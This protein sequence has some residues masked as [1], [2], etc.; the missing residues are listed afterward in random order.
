MN[1]ENT[2]L[3]YWENIL[4]ELEKGGFGWV[5]SCEGVKVTEVE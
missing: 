5:F 2:E 1:G 3:E 4:E